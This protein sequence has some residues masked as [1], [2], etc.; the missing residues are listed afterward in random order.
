MKMSLKKTELR[1][2]SLNEDAVQ[3]G[4]FL[5]VRVKVEV[6]SRL[7]LGKSILSKTYKDRGRNNTSMSKCITQPQQTVLAVGVTWETTDRAD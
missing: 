1:L 5:T 6:L 2:K 3:E 7:T 4:W